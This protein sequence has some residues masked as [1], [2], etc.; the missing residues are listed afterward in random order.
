VVYV[1]D[2]DQ[3]KVWLFPTTHSVNLLPLKHSMPNK[4]L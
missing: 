3:V 2:D 4:K 1:T